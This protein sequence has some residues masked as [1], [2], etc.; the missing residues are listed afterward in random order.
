[1]TTTEN[2]NENTPRA[3]STERL[4]VPTTNDNQSSLH[5][6]APSNPF[7]TSERSTTPLSNPFLGK[8]EK[9][10]PALRS[11][12]PI[13][14]HSRTASEGTIKRISKLQGQE[15]PSRPQL[16][17]RTQ[18]PAVPAKDSPSR[19]ASPATS[20]RKS[21]SPREQL[22]R[23]RS[24]ATGSPLRTES[25]HV[26][27]QGESKVKIP[28]IAT[29]REISPKDISNRTS[30]VQLSTARS[31]SVSKGKKQM[32][33]PVGSRIDQIHAHERYVDRRGALT[34]QIS[35][36]HKYQVSQELQIESV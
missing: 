14:P 27:T 1:M 8:D 34:P 18:G 6:P 35:G 30:A 36:G 11:D 7:S 15:A 33:V 26:R 25:P 28:V 21:S 3:G 31:V 4:R 10:L 24:P 32:L 19:S 5:S 2:T 23:T 29:E 17:I 20:M 16:N 13:Q 9:P 22:A 12:K